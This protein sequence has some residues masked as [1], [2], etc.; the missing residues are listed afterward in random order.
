MRA[1]GFFDRFIPRARREGARAREA[2]AR[3]LAG[4]LGGAVETFTEAGLPD[5]AAR[6]LLLRADAETSAEKRMAYCA[7]AARLAVGDD[8]KQQ[9]RAR[10]ALLSFD[11]LKGRGGA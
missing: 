2:R 1:V 6:V 3:E 11:V 4:D 9:A 10:K 7:L 5:E 8:I